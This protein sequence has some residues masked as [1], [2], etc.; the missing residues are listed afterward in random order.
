MGL[1]ALSRLS[2]ACGSPRGSPS[3]ADVSFYLGFYLDSDFIATGTSG[4]TLTSSKEG[5]D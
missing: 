5:Q 4:G 3:D 2:P 1:A